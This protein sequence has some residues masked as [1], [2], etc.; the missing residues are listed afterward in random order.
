MSS[1]VKA[2]MTM[3][4]RKNSFEALN[5]TYCGLRLRLMTWRAKMEG[6]KAMNCYTDERMVLMS[7][8]PA[9][10]A[11]YNRFSTGFQ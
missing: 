5:L 11:H 6:L 7:K 2:Q 3:I 1:H 10:N 4:A 8:S 9:W